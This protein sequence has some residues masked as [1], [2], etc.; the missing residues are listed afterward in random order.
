MLLVL[1]G[2]IL[3]FTMVQEATVV[4]PFEK[5]SVVIEQDVDA[6]PVELRFDRRVEPVDLVDE[7]H[8]ALFQVGQQG[9]KVAGLGDHR[10]GGGAEIHAQLTRHDLCQGGL[11]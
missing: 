2:S 7:Q 4:E 10:P 5:G 1:A 9:R 3:T 6:G 11:A 8:I